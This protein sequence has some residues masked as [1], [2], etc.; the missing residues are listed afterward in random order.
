M[1][2]RTYVL[3]LLATLAL[4]CLLYLP[5]QLVLLQ[6]GETLSFDQV[7]A[8]QQKSD[9]LYFGLAE[10]PGNYKFAAYAK[11]KPDIVVLGSSRAHQQHQEFYIKPSYTMSG[12]V[13]TPAD[14]IQT[15]DL[16]VQVHKPKYVIYNLDYFAFCTRFRGVSDQKS[17]SR[18]RGKP[19]TGWA[20]GSSN[21]FRL[22]PDLIQQGRLS[23]GQV[24]AL[25]M[26]RYPSAPQGHELIGMNALLDQR[27]FRLDG[28][29][30]NIN[31]FLQDPAFMEE[32]RK[33]IREGTLQFEGNCAYN[34]ETMAHLMML[35]EDMERQG[36]R[37]IVHMPPI[38]PDIYRRF[39]AARPDISGYFTVLLEQLARQRLHD[40]HNHVDGAVIG[41]PDIEFS[42]GYHGGDVTEA[43][44][45]LA[46]SQKGDTALAGIVNRPFLEKFIAMHHGEVVV[47]FPFYAATQ[48]VAWGVFGPKRP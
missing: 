25:A 24:W 45:I 33:Q 38:A 21:R 19:N 30:H 1:M 26:H 47:G 12:L 37:L 14:A 5:G 10:A 3:I 20:W 9:G 17:F 42:D 2:L 16:L 29:M 40:F 43:R 11:R 39:R 18:P 36:I 7:I 27:G 34:P 22:V 28:S 13:Y 41:A 8:R 31:G 23:L 44:S 35:Q 32:A 15:M 48:P 46:A 4:G 6:A